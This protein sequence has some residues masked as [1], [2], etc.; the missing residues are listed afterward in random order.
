LISPIGP[1][2]NG[3]SDI[4]R[5]I[6]PIGEENDI[7]I[8]DALYPQENFLLQENGGNLLLEDGIKIGW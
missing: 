8:H 2:R 4:A 5:A 6:L 3:I 7:R 1:L